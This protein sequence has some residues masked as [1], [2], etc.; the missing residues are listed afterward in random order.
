MCD[1]IDLQLGR[2]LRRRR[3]LL[4]LTQGQVATRCGVRFQQIQK[5]E[6][7]TNK[8]S[9]GMI[10]RLAQALSVEAGYFFD[11]LVVRSGV[12]AARPLGLARSR[13]TLAKAVRVTVS[14]AVQIGR[15]ARVTSS[16]G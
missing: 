5:Y 10:V 15:R 9:A 3:R 4:G 14:P 11:G 2:R 6:A 13:D 12:E 1:D 16:Q 8:I 7:A